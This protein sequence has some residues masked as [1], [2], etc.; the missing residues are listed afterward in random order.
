MLVHSPIVSYPQVD[1]I[2]PGPLP[3]RGSALHLGV[4]D[5]Q[6]PNARLLLERTLAGLRQ[7]GVVEGANFAQKPPN[8]PS[9]EASL[10]SLSSAAVEL[11]VVAS[12]DCGSCTSWCIHDAIELERRGKPAMVLVTTAFLALARAEAAAY[13]MPKLRIVEIPHPLGGALEADVARYAEQAVR[14]IELL[15]GRRR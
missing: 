3:A 2:E 8:L 10:A 4:L 13:G 6:K 5:N 15:L 1:P 9:A 14:S 7:H 12:A 11:V